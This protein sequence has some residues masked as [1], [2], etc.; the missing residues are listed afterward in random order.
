M[1]PI[2]SHTQ[3]T[4]GAYTES[5]LNLDAHNEPLRLHAQHY[6]ISYFAFGQ[7]L[8]ASSIVMSLESPCIYILLYICKEWLTST[9]AICPDFNA[10]ILCPFALVHPSPLQLRHQLH[11]PPPTYT[12]L[13]SPSS[14][15]WFWIWLWMSDVSVEYELC[16]G[17]VVCM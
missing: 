3:S 1:A 11:P 12:H 6:F 9:S 15:W 10:S 17:G 16:S 8:Y 2:R 7:L 14:H 4:Y 5:I 13:S